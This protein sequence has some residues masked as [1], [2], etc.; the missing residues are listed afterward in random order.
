MN[1]VFATLGL[2]YNSPNHMP[3]R[4]GN[5]VTVLYTTHIINEELLMCIILVYTMCSNS[6]LSDTSI[7]TF[8][9]MIDYGEL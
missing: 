4:P 8:E 6:G 7:Y 9:N 2:I 1:P 3:W 5:A